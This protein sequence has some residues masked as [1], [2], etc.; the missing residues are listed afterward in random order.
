MVVD[1]TGGVTPLPARPEPVEGLPF[2]IWC[3]LKYK[4]CFD[5]AQ[6]ERIYFNSVAN[7]AKAVT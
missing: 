4:Q 3:V 6:H 1:T 2:L 5:F 7:D